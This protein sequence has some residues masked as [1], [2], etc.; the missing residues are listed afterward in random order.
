LAR[1][2]EGRKLDHQRPASGN[3][4]LAHHKPDQE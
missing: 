4:G 2:A 3:V 1:A